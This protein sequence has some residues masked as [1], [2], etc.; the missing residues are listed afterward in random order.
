[1]RKPF[2]ATE[3]GIT[4]RTTSHFF[5]LDSSTRWAISTVASSRNVVDLMLL[6]SPAMLTSSPGICSFVPSRSTGT[7]NSLN[8]PS[9]A[10]TEPHCSTS[11]SR[12]ITTGGKGTPSTRNSSAKRSS[13][14]VPSPKHAIY[15][16]IHHAV[17][18]RIS[19]VK[20]ASPEISVERKAAN[21]ATPLS[22]STTNAIG[23][24]LKVRPGSRLA[25][26]K[27]QVTRGAT[28]S[29]YVYRSSARA[30]DTDDEIGRSHSTREVTNAKPNA[31][32]LLSG[33][34][35]AVIVAPDVLR[36]NWSDM[37]ETRHLRG[38]KRDLVVSRNSGLPQYLYRAPACAAPQ[39]P[40]CFLLSQQK[41]RRMIPQDSRPLR[42]PSTNA[43]GSG[44]ST[45]ER[46]T[47]RVFALRALSTL[48]LCAL[49][50][51]LNA[52]GG[53]NSLFSISGQ[54]ASNGVL[55]IAQS[56][57]D[58]GTVVPGS[59]KS[60]TLV[61]TNSGNATVTIDSATI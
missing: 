59:S 33:T 45:P 25:R 51:S 4:S 39:T 14:D 36:S 37:L 49:V 31:A 19:I 43:S 30:S 13:F 46:P 38:G 52:C 34:C 60:A 47:P 42:G 29:T 1:I 2:L 11:T 24:L 22:G 20:R 15:A 3:I 10:N 41:L 8:S 16:A 7:W 26:N 50:L 48:L 6:H 5:Q 32:A 61:A 23:T 27:I 21:A 53:L 17:R 55:S 58:F 57:V 35:P 28:S 12:S 18:H 54:S 56:S 44:A 9:V 40:S